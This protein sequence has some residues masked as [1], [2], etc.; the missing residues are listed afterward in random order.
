MAKQKI[1]LDEIVVENK[2]VGNSMSTS[3]T[4]NGKEL[5]VKWKGNKQIIPAKS[6]QSFIIDCNGGIP[7]I[8]KFQYPKNPWKLVSMM[9]GYIYMENRFSDKSELISTY[10]VRDDDYCYYISQI[11]PYGTAG[12]YVRKIGLIENRFEYSEQ[13][14]SEG[15]KHK[16]LFVAKDFTIGEF[17]EVCRKHFGEESTLRLPKNDKYSFWEYANKFEY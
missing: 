9:Y 13:Y 11:S 10:E 2:R 14:Q 4:F 6:G 16:Y 17:K 3:Y 1:T 12:L 15:I 7:N 8:Y 5:I